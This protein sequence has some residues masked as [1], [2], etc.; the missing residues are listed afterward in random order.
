MSKPSHIHRSHTAHRTEDVIYDIHN[1][2]INIKTNEIFLFGHN[3]HIGGDDEPGVEFGMANQFIKNLTVLMSHSTKPILIHM[4]TC[5]GHWAEGMAI[6]NAIQACPNYICILSYTHARSMSSLILQAADKRVMMKDST[7]M[8]H[9]GT[10]SM[11][12]TVKQYL[13]EGEELVK[14]GN[15]MMGIYKERMAEAPIFKKYSDKRLH[16]WL[17]DKMDRKEDVYLSAKDAVKYG[18]ADEVFGEEG[19]FDWDDLKKVD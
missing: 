16:K 13:T 11:S 5:G 10:M 4:K 1:H 19:T 15:R 12:G 17:T 18:F 6:H 9:E 14:S 3:S 2:G 8:F 7:F